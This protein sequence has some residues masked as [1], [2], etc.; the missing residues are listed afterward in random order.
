MA[1]RRSTKSI[2]GA[3][4]GVEGAD[5]GGIRELGHDPVQPPDQRNQR[6]RYI[7]VMPHATGSPGHAYWR[8]GFL[9]VLTTCF[10]QRATTEISRSAPALAGRA[11]ATK[12]VTAA[13]VV[14]DRRGCRRVTR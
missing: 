11:G 10:T 3:R 12:A 1:D 13:A 14:F 2:P 9:T 8:P 7:S 5:H 6:R 4:D